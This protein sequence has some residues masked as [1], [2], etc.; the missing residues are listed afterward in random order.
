MKRPLIVTLVFALVSLFALPALAAPK[1]A[2]MDFDNQSQH[3][4]WKVGRGAA[5]ILTTSLVKQTD[6]DIFE[7]ERLNTIMKE[8]NLGSSG[9]VDPSTAAKIGKIIGVQ[10]IVTGAVTEYGQS[11]AGAGGGGV[12]VG[13]KGYAA[14]VDVRIIDV[15]TSRILF[16]DTGNGSKSSVNVRVFGFGGGESWNEKHATQAMRDAIEQ[17]TQKLVASDFAQKASANTKANAAPVAT[18]PVL[19]ADVTGK[20]VILNAGSSAGLTAGQTLTIKRKGREIKDPASGAV[21]KVIYDTLGKIKLT[22]VESSY[23]EGTIT[24]GSGFKV[25]DSAHP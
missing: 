5:D 16:A 25:G 2:V 6:F 19:L 22:N 17:V 10:Y 18:G 11:K 24:E 13:K 3:G 14:T 7:R 15:N 20:S 8:Q 23:A 4:G 1:V 9:R 12:R 21:L